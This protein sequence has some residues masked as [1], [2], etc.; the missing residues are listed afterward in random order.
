MCVDVKVRPAA[1]G[2]VQSYAVTPFEQISQGAHLDSDQANLTRVHQLWS[3]V[4][5][6]ELRSLYPL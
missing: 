2:N 5:V 3:P 6:S 4:V 1:A